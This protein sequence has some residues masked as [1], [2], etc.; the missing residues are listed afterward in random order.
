MLNSVTLIGKLAGRP[1][2][3]DNHPAANI[4]H[5]VA[6][7]VES[8]DEQNRAVIDVC[9][10]EPLAQT[11]NEKYSEGTVVGIKGYL[12]DLHNQ[13]YVVATRVSFMTP[14]EADND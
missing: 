14:M 5:K 12:Q 6:L 3:S 10:W 9:I 4:T 13:L 1:V 7:D 11:I 2:E 8:T